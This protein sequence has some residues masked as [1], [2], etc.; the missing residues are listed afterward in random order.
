MKSIAQ[1]G[2]CPILSIAFGFLAVPDI[3]AEPVTFKSASPYQL[4]ELISVARPSYDLAIS[5]ELVYPKVTN[6]NMPA[7]VFMHGSGGKLLRHHQ[8]LELARALGFVTLQIDSFGSRGVSSTVGNQRN[9]TAA[10]MTIDLLRALKFLTGHPNV[11]PRRIIVM[12]SSKG[13]IAALYATW[14]PIRRKVVGTIDYAGYLLLYPLCVAI[15]DRNVTSNSVHVFIG[16]KDN[17]TPAA[18]CVEQV[19]RMIKLGRNWSITIY[20][21]AYHGFDSPI[22]GI[23]L[24]PHAYSMVDCNLALRADGYEYEI[25][26]G[27]LLTKSERLRA[28]RSCAK[29]GFVKIGGQHPAKNTLLRDIQEFLKSVSK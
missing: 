2:C 3:A 10:M 15:E 8:Y 16:E 21:G 29:K 28:F 12:G 9:V 5:A 25:G 24:M 11:D 6:D 4:G 1:W 27:F 13:A 20:K 22:E 7:F 14:S 23:R 19:D 18:P 26:S 17:W